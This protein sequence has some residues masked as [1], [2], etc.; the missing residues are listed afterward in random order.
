MIKT[1]KMPNYTIVQNCDGLTFGIPDFD[2]DLSRGN[3]SKPS[4]QDLQL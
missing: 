4:Y 2:Q 1:I 3:I